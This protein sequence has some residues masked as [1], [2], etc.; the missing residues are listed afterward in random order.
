MLSATKYAPNEHIRLLECMFTNDR[1]D[2]KH[3]VA[4]PYK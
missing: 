3:S 2:M 1:V 4:K